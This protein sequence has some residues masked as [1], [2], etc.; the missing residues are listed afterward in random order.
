MARSSARS[1][2]AFIGVHPLRG[3]GSRTARSA[4]GPGAC[5]SSRRPRA[6]PPGR[7]VRDRGA[8]SRRRRGPR[9]GRVDEAWRQRSN[10]G[11]CP[12]DAIP[13]RTPA[14]VV[15]ST[16][17]AVRRARSPDGYPASHG[18]S[19]RHDHPRRRDR[20]RGRGG[21]APGPGRRR[22]RDRVDRDA[23]GRG[24][25]RDARRAPA[26]RDRRRDPRLPRRDQGADHDAGR[27]RVPQRERRAASGSRPVRRGPSRAVAAGR[28][29]PARRRRPRDRPGEH[30][31]PVPGHRVRTRLGG[32]R[33]AQAAAPRRRR[34]GA[35]GRRGHHAEADQRH[36]RAPDR[37]VRV[38]VRALTPAQ[39]RDGRPQGQR[40]ALL[41]R[42][43]PRGRDRG[44]ARPSPTSIG[45]RSR[46]TICP[47][48]SHAPPRTSTSCSCRTSTATSS[49]TSA[50]GSSA[51]SG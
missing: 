44:R 42:H 9:G 29:D 47:R 11:S 26:R 49:P 50:R 24:R 34:A 8:R 13:G 12:N 27:H 21:D 19:P 23:G 22:R 41:R 33:R 4:P 40:D 2:R 14:T 38:R 3:R 37:A 39:A 46:S 10:V 36:R 31:G 16:L 18:E 7:R 45:T 5:P 32:D 30:R 6:S 15:R 35:A 25:A 48:G 43:L 1:S 17:T 20:P 28:D 51:G